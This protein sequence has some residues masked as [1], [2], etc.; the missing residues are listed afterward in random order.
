M[1]NLYYVILTNLV[2]LLS[3]VTFIILITIHIVK[4][5]TPKVI[6]YIILC[7]CILGMYLF[8]PSRYVYLGYAL[9]SPELLKKSIKYSINPYEKRLSYFYL[10]NIYN[11]D[12]SGEGI[13]NGNLAIEYYEKALQKEYSKYPSETNSLAL[14]YSIKGDYDKTIELNK[15]LN[16]SQSISLLNI[17]IVN[18]EYEKAL[19]TFEDNDNSIDNFLKA[20]LYRKVGNLKKAELTQ[21]LTNNIYQNKLNITKGKV[22]RVKFIEK[23]EKYKT[24]DAY[25]NWLK[26]QAKEYK[27]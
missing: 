11:Y 24:I 26:E 21:K 16:L 25:K 10:A 22:N 1:D 15:I 27:F 5:K 14:L 19:S 4:R 7:L 18:D 8:I 6:S 20:D 17:Y 12:T 2:V 9:Q 13:K 23:A 3:F